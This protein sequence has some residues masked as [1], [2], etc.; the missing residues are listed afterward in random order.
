[1]PAAFARAVVG[2]RADD[3]IGLLKQGVDLPNVRLDGVP[4]YPTPIAIELTADD[5]VAGDAEIARL[6]DRIEDAGL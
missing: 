4:G 5:L 3:P 1:M 2:L 6:L